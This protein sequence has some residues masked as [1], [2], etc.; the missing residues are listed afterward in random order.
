MIE[1]ILLHDI[2]ERYDSYARSA[3]F[4][5]HAT[6]VL[7]QCPPHGTACEID[8]GAGYVSVWLSQ[9][10]VQATGLVPEEGTVERSRQ[11]NELL[12]GGADFACGEPF[13]FYETGKRYD[14]V[15]HQD[16]LHRFAVPWIR[17]LLAQQVA[18][19]G[20]VV[21]SVPSVYRAKQGDLHERLLSIE[22]WRRILEPFTVLELRYYGD[23]PAPDASESGAPELP[24]DAIGGEGGHRHHDRILCVLAG[25]TVDEQLLQ[26]MTVSDAPYLPGISAIVQTRNEERNL[27]ACLQS[28]QGWTDEIIVCDMGSTDR[29]VEIA[30]RFGAQVMT[31]PLLL[32]FDRARNVAAMRAGY[33]WICYLD[34]DERVPQGWGSKLRDRLLS[35]TTDLAALGTP[36]NYFF[37]GKAMQSMYPQYKAP[38]F[39]RNGKFV[40]NAGV[41]EGASVFGRTV[42]TRPENPAESILHYSYEGLDHYLD[43]LKGYSTAEA[44]KLEARGAQ[45]HW[46]ASIEG[47][48]REF[49]QYYDHQ[50]A[51]RDGGHG[52]IWSFMNGVYRFM[53]HAKLYERHFMGP[54]LSEGENAV[55]ASLEEVL[56]YALRVVREKP[57]ASSVRPPAIAVLEPREP[58]G[59]QPSVGQ[60]QTTE[61]NVSVSPQQHEAM[62]TAP[63]GQ[64]A[65][66][67]QTPGPQPTISLCMI[68]RNEERV[69]DACLKSIRPWVDEIILVDTG[70][71]DGTVAIAERHGARV[72]HFPWTES[73]SEARNVS[74]DHATGDWIFWMDADD[75]IPANCGRGLRD[76]VRQAAEGVTGF[77][78]QVHIPPAPGE[79]GFTTV[80]HVKLFRNRPGIRFEGRI[81]EQILESIYKSGGTVERSPLHVVHSGYDYSPEGQVRK[82]ER[83][84]TLL[85][86][87]LEERPDHPFVLFNIGMTAYHT[88]DFERALPALKRCLEVAK[89]RES[90]VRKVYAMLAGC[91]LEQGDLPQARATIERGLELFPRDPELLFRGGIVYRE[92]KDL[93]AAERCYVT[94]LNGRETGHIDSLDISM[95]SFKAHHNLALIYLD[96]PR[97]VEAERHWRAA[98]QAHPRFV[99]SWLGLGE[100]YLRQQ[101]GKELQSVIATL[102]GLDPAAAQSL[103]RYIE[104][105]PLVDPVLD[106]TREGVTA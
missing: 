13:A 49:Q 11:I 105:Q 43:K 28:L 41:H 44:M 34:A 81:H 62:A 22:E 99:P 100:L 14:V 75:T 47:F 17:A 3:S 80:D 18:S 6:A 60:A 8:C 29:T 66:R 23:L 93:N 79:E 90:I 30:R 87:D 65:Q 20:R 53:Q 104:P 70:S 55:P 63:L 97:P 16:R 58:S 46:Q 83:D 86:K 25:Q 42:Y 48:V 64:Q 72:V 77:L 102:Q 35:D 85:N 52:F 61:T 1:T 84:W 69:L 59:E 73:F 82:R 31:H 96:M 26:M 4:R 7:C 40:Y 57:A 71:E 38:P 67:Q 33:S 24:L 106:Q 89:P 74:L 27:E 98:V 103:R 54:G 50:G 39:Y 51:A 10:A 5:E 19:A 21:F 32:N 12:Q 15:H 9:R 68:V 88:K 76:L 101:R 2:R 95:T 94:L 45:F 36:Y 78:M 91:Y 92:I 56:E 37:M